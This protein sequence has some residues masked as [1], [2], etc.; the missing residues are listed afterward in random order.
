M[1][2]VKLPVAAV[3]GLAMTATAACAPQRAERLEA[4]TPI[5]PPPALEAPAPPQRPELDYAAPVLHVD[6]TIVDPDPTAEL[7]WPLGLSEH[8]E[9][10]PHF[11]VAKVLAEPDVDWIELCKMGAHKRTIPKLR[12]ELGYLR[13]W[14]AAGA[15]DTAAAIDGLMK[16]RSTVVPG[17]AAAIRADVSNIL[18]SHDPSS[19]RHM[20]KT[21]RLSDE[22]DIV[23]RLAATYVEAG[24]LGGAIEIN[25][26][27]IAN[28]SGRTPAK[29]CQRL[30]RRV[31]LDPDTYRTSRSAFSAKAP[32]PGFA[33]DSTDLLFGAKLDADRRC[34]ELDAELSC[35]LAKEN[36]SAWYAMHG[37]SEGLA[38]LLAATAAWPTGKFRANPDAWWHVIPR[39]L[40]A[41]PQKEAYEAVVTAT[42]ATLRLTHCR[43]DFGMNRVRDVLRE[44]VTDTALPPGYVERLKQLDE[45]R[46]ALCWKQP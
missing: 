11:D 17:L 31:L 19:A 3:V 5:Q 26:L 13:A 40:D 46:S 30:A 34:K 23:D 44:L 20:I 43:D 1:P 6:I 37:V 8:P 41:R 25:E 14:C 33:D 10:V 35:W 15:N 28:D 12:D 2:L 39:A 22:P 7:R 9:L 45:K 27:A 4:P 42:E 21:F 32:V 24:K 29:T 38:N 36:C 18:V 16:L